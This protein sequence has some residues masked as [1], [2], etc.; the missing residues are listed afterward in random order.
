MEKRYLTP[1][2][3]DAYE[4]KLQLEEKS[5]FTVDKYIRDCKIFLNFTAG[6]PVTR[7]MVVEYKN[8]LLRKK[9]K[10]GSINSYILS[11]N[12]FFSWLGWKDLRLKTLRIQRPVYC[13]SDRELTVAEYK[14]LCKTA[15]KRN[16]IRLSLIMQTLASTG[17]RVSELQFITVEAV[18]AGEALVLAKGKVRNVFLLDD[19]RQKLADFAKENNIISGA[20]FVNSVGEPLDRSIIWALMKSVS[21][22]CGVSPK[23]VYPHNLRHLFARQFYSIDKDICK[24]ADVLGHSDVNTTR[25]YIISSGAE[26]RELLEKMNL[27]L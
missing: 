2:L 20:L 5:R 12:C 21:K 1:E 13:S 11:L 24:L 7:E 6:M 16:N 14:L 15:Q 26:H 18:Q 9:Y 19:L 10:R 4:K 3:L 25:L 23:K 22:A 17:I 27:V 8:N